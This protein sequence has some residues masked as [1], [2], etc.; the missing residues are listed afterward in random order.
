MTALACPVCRSA[1]AGRVAGLALTALLTACTDGA[2][3]IAYDIEA[4]AATFR[5]ASATRYSIKHVPE[6]EPEGCG[7]PYKVQLSGR[8]ALVIWCMDAS[9]RVV[10][11][12]TTTYHLNFVDVPR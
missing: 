6:G 5:N 9:S 10:A 2:T 1:L 12:H 7:G 4:G 8:S 11:S 3:R